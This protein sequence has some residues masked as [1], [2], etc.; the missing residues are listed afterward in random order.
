MASPESLFCA[1]AQKRY[2][3]ISSSIDAAIIAP[4]YALRIYKNALRRFEILVLNAVDTSLTSIESKIWGMIDL[5]KMD[6]FNRFQESSM[7][8]CE[9]AY[10]CEAVRETLF[11]TEN[12][13]SVGGDSGDD[14]D[15]VKSIPVS[16][17]NSLRNYSDSN[18]YQTFE[19]YVC[20]LS[21]RR[22]L[23]QYIIDF[24]DTIETQLNVLLNKLGINK[25]DEIIQT[26]FNTIG[27]FFSYLAL[28]E[29]FANCAF[30][31]CNFVQT[32][33][34]K[35]EDVTDKL[36]IEQQGSG[37]IIKRTDY[38]NYVYSKELELRQRIIEL[39]ELISKNKPFRDGPKSDE[40]MKT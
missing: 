31:T 15:F 6:I 39:K 37:W 34:N 10:T 35:K 32:A 20:K 38:L 30:S 40:V 27:P 36:E 29:K 5:Y 7:A 26:Y 17:R 16:I 3:E 21:I 1:L 24:L 28:L 14:P 8:F 19:K 18:T 11:P 22:I 23:N 33:L 9:L 2:D 12:D 25:I 4:V 13:P